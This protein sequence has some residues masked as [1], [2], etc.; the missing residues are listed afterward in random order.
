M[1]NPHFRSRR[2]LFIGECFW[3][4]LTILLGGGAALWSH[5]GVEEASAGDSLSHLRR[6]AR[7]EVRT[8]YRPT[9]HRPS[10]ESA[11]A[12]VGQITLCQPLPGNCPANPCKLNDSHNFTDAQLNADHVGPDALV[13]AGEQSS[14]WVFQLNSRWFS[15]RRNHPGLARRRR[16]RAPAPASSGLETAAAKAQKRG[17]AVLL[18]RQQIL[19]R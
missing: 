2:K 5:E 1:S 12:G 7:R 10:S 18:R 11:P 17:C 3:P 8:Q 4:K 14:P 19:M 9:P 15:L 16:V 13:R 6:Q